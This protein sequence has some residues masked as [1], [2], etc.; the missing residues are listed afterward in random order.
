MLYSLAESNFGECWQTN[1]RHWLFADLWGNRELYSPNRGSIHISCVAPE[2]GSAKC[3]A[4]SMEL[5]SS[6]RFCDNHTWATTNNSYSILVIFTVYSIFSSLF[7]QTD[8][9]LQCETV[10]AP[11]FP[12]QISADFLSLAVEAGLRLGQ[13]CFQITVCRDTFMDM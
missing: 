1:L 10:F 11:V 13:H 12:G 4:T 8:T 9:S 5:S 2:P 6:Y 7:I 3:E